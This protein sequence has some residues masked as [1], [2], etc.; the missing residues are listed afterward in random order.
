MGPP[1]MFMDGGCGMAET[2]NAVDDDC[3]GA[4]DEN[5]GGPRGENIC[6]D[7]TRAVSPGG[8]TYQICPFSVE[9]TEARDLCRLSAY[10]LASPETMAEDT[11]LDS[12]LI[13]GGDYWIGLNDR[14]SEGDFEW[15]DAAGD[16]PLG[17]FND[18]DTSIG[19]PNGGD[20]DDCV[21]IEFGGKRW[22]DSDCEGFFQDDHYF[23]CEA[24]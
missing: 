19:E 12:V 13:A 7:C 22:R 2:C 9:W 5:P 10:E 14:D 1:D 16:R 11:F 24:P 20:G 8:V 18:W 3:D 17:G 4:I 15:E 6:P 21:R 23:A